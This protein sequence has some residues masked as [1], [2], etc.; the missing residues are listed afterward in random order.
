VLVT[1]L[2][3]L[4]SVGFT[5]T[6]LAVSIPTIADDVGS[7]KDVLTWVVTG[8]L[9][10]FGVLGPAAG[11]AG[12]MWGHRR[13][14]LIGTAL[15]AVFSALTAMAPGAGSLIAFRVLG[16]AAGA[17]AG[18]ASMAMIN[19]L[20]PREERVR[21]MGWF[22]FV[23]AGAPVLGV[24]AGGPVV[25]HLSWRLIFVAQAPMLAVVCAISFA[26]LPE[27]ER[28]AKA[29]FDAAGAFTLAVGVTSVLF[30]LNRAGPLGFEHPA[31]VAGFVLAPVALFT[32]V[33]VERRAAEPLIPLEFFRRR[34]FVVPAVA[35][36][37]TNFAYMGGFIITPLFLQEVYAYGETRIGVISISRPIFYAVTAPVAGYLA[38]RVGERN[39]GV[40]GAAAVAASMLMLAGLGS[41]SPDLLIMGS[42]A[43][44]GVGLGASSP[45]MQA[46]VANAVDDESLGVAGAT[47]QLMMQVGIVTGIQL[48]Q[49]LQVAREDTVGL[50]G[51][52][53]EAYLLGFLAAAC[54]LVAA[55]FV[56]STE[57]R[58]E[59]TP[60]PPDDPVVVGVGAEIITP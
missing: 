8:P 35:Q 57:R 45:A 42:L 46:S 55:T 18:P 59:V 12:D 33:V 2:S 58:S 43:L 41:S 49:T 21:A 50:V 38:V 15:A 29:R 31:V 27:V 5:I 39:A 34:N 44:S 11:K 52:Y 14:Y 1:V 20:Y 37:F 32:F 22:S 19:R 23:A 4:F 13:L 10:A 6:I 60:A 7:S 16:A 47:M 54:A 28:T 51:S 56:R 30:A 17:A 53:R 40:V 3:G 48:M 24:V 9:L 25:E 36:F 26:I